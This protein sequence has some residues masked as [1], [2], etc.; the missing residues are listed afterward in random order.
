MTGSTRC[1]EL[2]DALTD[3]ATGVADGAT[4]ATVSAHLAG[5]G[6][7]RDELSSLAETADEL[8]LLA[9]ERDPSAD[10]EGRVLARLHAAGPARPASVRRHRTRRVLVAATAAALVVAGGVGTWWATAPDRELAA[11]YRETLDVADGHYF[12]AAD[13]VAGD[14]STGPG[15]SVGTVFL[16]DGEPSWVFVLVR[17]P[18]AAAAYD[19]V[20]TVGAEDDGAEDDR[21]EGGAA[22]RDVA[23]GRCVVT[24]GSCS[25]GGVL[26][27]AAH[28][29]RAVRLVDPAGTVWATA[30]R[31]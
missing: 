22:G 25:T 3:V 15:R 20:V 21:P 18:G 23:L 10:F 29:V 8:L 24:S 2:R 1:G 19:V 9:P 6:R 7:C 4:R 5:C 13:L 17:D 26:D 28:D 30:T 11:S 12:A 27:G 31:D 16:Y 14:A